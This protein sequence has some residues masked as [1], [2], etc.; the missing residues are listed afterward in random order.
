M[1]SIRV[2][3]VELNQRLS[4]QPCHHATPSTT[5]SSTSSPLTHSPTTSSTATRGKTR[6]QTASSPSPSTSVS[7]SIG[8]ANKR[9]HD[10]QNIQQYSQGCRNVLDHHVTLATQTGHVVCHSKVG[11][12]VTYSA[13]LIP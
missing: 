10:S 9:T 12:K 3:L 5:P 2:Q 1:D 8:R 7:P 11:V 13:G 6:S 4:G